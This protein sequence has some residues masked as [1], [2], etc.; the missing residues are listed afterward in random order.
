[1]RVA[2]MLY[3]K[4]KCCGGSIDFVLRTGEEI[5]TCTRCNELMLHELIKLYFQRR[6]RGDARLD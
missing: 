1:M 6:Q 4:C 3:P 2:E 5:D